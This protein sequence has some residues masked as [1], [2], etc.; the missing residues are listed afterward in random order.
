MTTETETTV[1]TCRASVI[2][3]HIEEIKNGMFTVIFLKKDGT[4]RKMHGRRGVKKDLKGGV[5]TIKDHPNLIGM[6]ENKTSYRCFDANRVL[7][8][9]GA[10]MVTKVTG[11]GN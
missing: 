10:G 6:Y 7:E 8:L 4:E 9:R 3:A 1:K 5:S 2:H 11:R